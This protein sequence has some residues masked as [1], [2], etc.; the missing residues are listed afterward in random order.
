MGVRPA[1][2]AAVAPRGE[3]EG[4]LARRDQGTGTE[5][6]RVRHG[7]APP[8]AGHG[9]VV[10]EVRGDVVDGDDEEKREEDT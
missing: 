8:I 2:V 1:A 5:G 9:A 3:G 7:I 10:D 4:L 6:G